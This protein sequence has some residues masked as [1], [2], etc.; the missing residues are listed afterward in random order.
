MG[1]GDWEIEASGL[2][3]GLFIWSLKICGYFW[4]LKTSPYLHSGYSIPLSLNLEWLSLKDGS[5]SP[6]HASIT[7]TS[8]PSDTIEHGMMLLTCNGERE[9]ERDKVALELR[10]QWVGIFKVM[11][12]KTISQEL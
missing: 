3:N 8:A 9:W 4:L 7:K 2:F 5:V 12:D 11:K 6:Q 1:N 10:R